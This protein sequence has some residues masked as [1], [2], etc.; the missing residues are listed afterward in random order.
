MLAEVTSSRL[1]L[2]QLTTEIIPCILVRL[3]NVIFPDRTSANVPPC[4]VVGHCLLFSYLWFQSGPF[5][6]P[7]LDC[8]LGI[9]PG[10]VSAPSYRQGRPWVGKSPDQ[11]HLPN[12]P[13][14]ATLTLSGINLSGFGTSPTGTWPPKYLLMCINISDTQTVCETGIWISRSGAKV[15]VLEDLRLPL[16]ACS[17]Q[18]L[19]LLA[20]VHHDGQSETARHRK[21]DPR[22]SQYLSTDL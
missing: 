7:S 10:L 19:K 9:V 2:K 6:F 8:I 17:G 12:H 13:S 20:S 14:T 3:A 1:H 21:Q 11:R 4:Q 18:E 15:Y 16:L 22:R 5:F